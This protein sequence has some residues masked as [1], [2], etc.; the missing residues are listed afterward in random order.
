M[1]F[2]A[3][4]RTA[5]SAVRSEALDTISFKNGPFFL[6]YNQRL[7][8]STTVETPCPGDPRQQGLPQLNHSAAFVVSPAHRRKTGLGQKAVFRH[9][10]DV[11]PSIPLIP[12]PLCPKYRAMNRPQGSAEHQGY[13]HVTCCSVVE[14]SVE[15]VEQAG[16]HLG[17]KRT[18]DNTASTQAHTHFYSRTGMF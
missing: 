7:P 11:V 17:L 12:D 4:R 9:R 14:L 1:V 18:P 2:H 16:L 8:S 6:I 15:R 5:R 10:R 13:E 3:K